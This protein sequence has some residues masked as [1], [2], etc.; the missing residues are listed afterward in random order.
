MNH[1]QMEEVLF[2]NSVNTP[3]KVYTVIKKTKNNRNV[4]VGMKFVLYVG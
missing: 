1:Q 4:A 2:H 3:M